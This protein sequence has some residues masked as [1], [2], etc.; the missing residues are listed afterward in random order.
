[1][2]A[3]VSLEETESG[4]P[5][6]SEPRRNR[7]RLPG[8]TPLRELP[9]SQPWR[10]VRLITGH[11]I[12]MAAQFNCK[13]GFKSMP[14]SLLN[15][16]LDRLTNTWDAQKGK[17]TPLPPLLPKEKKSDN[18]AVAVRTSKSHQLKEKQPA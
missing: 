4:V 11:T 9:K 1:M 7:Q 18:E 13:I 8:H 16:K 3:Y 5:A 2:A 6:R 17:I 15:S 14:M 12:L 10:R